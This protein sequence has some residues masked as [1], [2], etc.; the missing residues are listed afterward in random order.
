MPLKTLTS[1]WTAILLVTLK[2]SFD[3]L[4]SSILVHI[5]NAKTKHLVK[6][7]LKS[8]EHWL[9]QNIYVLQSRIFSHF[10]SRCTHHYVEQNLRI[11][12]R[13]S[14]VWNSH[15]FFHG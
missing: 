1:L 6:L 9:Q 8:H 15:F 2:L 11:S 4:L 3:L 7:I 5:L 12:F 10:P 14:N 13:L